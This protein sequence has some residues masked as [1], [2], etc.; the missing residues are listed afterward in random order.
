MKVVVIW[1]VPLLNRVFYHFL[2]F[3]NYLFMVL[4]FIF[5]YIY[6]HI[7]S[8]PYDTVGPSRSFHPYD[9]RT[10]STFRNVPPVSYGNGYTLTD[11]TRP[12]FL[13]L[14]LVFHF[15]VILYLFLRCN[16][17]ISPAWHQIV[18]IYLLPKPSP[19]N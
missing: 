6:V 17:S 10:N 1:W 18:C 16:K 8:P 9:H 5:I 15:V 3:V 19:S 2:Y 7:S 14:R 13:Y 12:T 11:I 4:W